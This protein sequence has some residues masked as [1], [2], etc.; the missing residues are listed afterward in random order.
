MNEQRT[1]VGQDDQGLT[2]FLIKRFGQI[3]RLELEGMRQNYPILISFPSPT[4]AEWIFQYGGL[5]HD[6]LT[7]IAFSER[8]PFGQIRQQFIALFSQQTQKLMR[9]CRLPTP[10]LEHSGLLAV[11]LA[12]ASRQVEVADRNRAEKLFREFVSLDLYQAIF[13]PALL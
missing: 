1:V 12:K 2:L 11:S 8:Q 7:K 9:L 4:Q 6:C 5:H 13:Q 3:N 10:E